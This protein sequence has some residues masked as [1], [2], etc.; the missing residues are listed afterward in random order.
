MSDFFVRR[1][2]ILAC[3]AAGLLI[4]PYTLST[5]CATA[6]KPTRAASEF[7]LFVENDMLAHTDRYYTNGIKFGIGVPGD[8]M[9]ELLCN[10]SSLSFSPFVNKEELHFGWFL[11]QNIYT[12]KSIAVAA[13]QP[14]DR[15]WAAWLYLG[16]VVQRADDKN[17]DTVEVDVGMVG[18]AALGEQVQTAWH[19]LVGTAGPR[20]WGNQIPNEPALL[21]SYVHKHKF[22]SEYIELIPHVG[23]TVGNV[24][25]L[26]RAGGIVRVGI[27][28]TGFGPD[29]I[30]P[31]GAM[32]QS[33]R[34]AHDADLRDK[35]EV[36]GFA[37]VDAR[38]VARNIFLD[39]T[40]FRDS[41]SVSRR[42]YV[43]DISVGASIRYQGY[44]ISLTHI[45]RS[46]EFYTATGGGGKQRFDSVNLGIDF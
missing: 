22:K 18:P 32:L 2:R 10:F 28:M 16:G 30:E 9:D 42:D 46:E 25:T 23:A 36:Y 38:L 19:H 15:P 26:A 5:E 11:G 17:L 20:G 34:N 40:M 41:P 21:V 29:G 33:T 35:L 1:L 31:G 37:G 24:F 44:R 6:K 7:Q 8:T 45:I 13:P 12:P 4:S 27:H 43:H 3:L 39:G 14:F